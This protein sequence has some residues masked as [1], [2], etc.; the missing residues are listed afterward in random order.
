MPPTYCLKETLVR[1]NKLLLAGTSFQNFPMGANLHKRE[2]TLVLVQSQEG[3]GQQP[4]PPAP[5]LRPWFL[6]SRTRVGI[7]IT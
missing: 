5:K 7:Q 6:I 1:I 4:P 3:E 2:M